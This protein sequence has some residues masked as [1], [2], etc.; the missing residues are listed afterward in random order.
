M[1]FCRKEKCR[2]EKNRKPNSIVIST[3]QPPVVVTTNPH[4]GNPLSQ[5]LR[6]KHDDPN[7]WGFENATPS[8]RLASRLFSLFVRF[9][10]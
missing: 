10:F 2:K 4:F 7:P 1:P 6:F 5:P 8:H 9:P 3:R